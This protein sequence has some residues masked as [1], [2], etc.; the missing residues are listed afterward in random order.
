VKDQILLLWLADGE[1][2]LRHRTL[3]IW[4]WGWVAAIFVVDRL[5][6]KKH[7]TRI[8]RIIEEPVE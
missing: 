5:N 2:V 1:I 4:A 3:R 7:R 6:D 8:I